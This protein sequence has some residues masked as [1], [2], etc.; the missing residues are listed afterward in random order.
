MNEEVK[1]F[2]KYGFRVCVK[3]DCI[4][5]GECLRYHIW[6]NYS[7]V[8]DNILIINPLS[9]KT[10]E[11]CKFFRPIEPIILAYGFDKSMYDDLPKKKSENLWKKIHNHF[12]NTEYYRYLRGE[13]PLFPAQQEYLEQAFHMAGYQGEIKYLRKEESFDL[14]DVIMSDDDS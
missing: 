5:K 4:K 3:E 14:H 9:D 13:K 1:N 11:N 2:R 8:Y 7:K 10:R 6:Q 12:G